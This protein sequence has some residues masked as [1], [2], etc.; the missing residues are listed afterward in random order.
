M[1]LKLAGKEAGESPALVRRAIKSQA[2][3]R[4]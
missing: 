1:G 2:A 3:D 4:G